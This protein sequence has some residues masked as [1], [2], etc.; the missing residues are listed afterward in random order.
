MISFGKHIAF[1]HPTNAVSFL[2]LILFPD[3][4]SFFFFLFH[5]AVCHSLQSG[6]PLHAGD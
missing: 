3:I 4:Q 2:P 6:Y 5:R 1:E